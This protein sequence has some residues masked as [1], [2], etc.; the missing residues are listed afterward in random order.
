MGCSPPSSLFF[1]QLSHRVCPKGPVDFTYPIKHFPACPVNSG[2]S[3]IS[4][5]TCAEKSIH[6]SRRI[7]EL[8]LLP[9]RQFL[10]ARDRHLNARNRV[11]CTFVAQTYLLCLRT[12]ISQIFH[13]SK[14]PFSAGD[15]QKRIRQMTH[16]SGSKTEEFR[17]LFL[18]L[19][20]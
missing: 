7:V 18:F 6:L 15:D 5:R 11:V 20:F 9:A 13:K 3:S 12:S 16:S 2:A 4:A 19:W 17:I 1:P 10:S 14:G 8:C